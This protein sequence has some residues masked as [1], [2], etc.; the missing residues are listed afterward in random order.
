MIRHQDEGMQGIRACVA[1]IQQS[2][3]ESIA[4]FGGDEKRTAF[5]GTGRNEVGA[6]K[7]LVAL[8]DGHDLSG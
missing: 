5:P 7:A 1:I 8:G 3:D 4:D 2:H 6:R